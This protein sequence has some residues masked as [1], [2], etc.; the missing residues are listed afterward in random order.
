M[1]N[2]NTE[3]S[4]N[5]FQAALYKDPDM[6]TTAIAKKFGVSRSAITTAKLILEFG[7]ADEINAAEGAKV[8]LRT[9]ADTIRDRLTP[10]QRHEYQARRYVAPVW[11]PERRGNHSD[12]AS[13]WAKFGPALKTFTEMPNQADLIE[14]VIKRNSMRVNAV[15][16]YLETAA[17]WM[18]EFLNEWRKY[19]QPK[20][21]P[22]DA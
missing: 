1:A 22:S 18:E 16:K 2:N 13:F 5:A 9:M 4:K 7:T 3:T 10:E 8:G 20:G 14:N 6:N 19:K 12:E 15:D 21:D 11:T 17:K